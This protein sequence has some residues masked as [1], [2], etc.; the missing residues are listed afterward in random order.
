MKLFAAN[1]MMT[2]ITCVVR[3]CFLGFM[4]ITISGQYLEKS[5]IVMYSCGSLFEVYI[6]CSGVQKLLDVSTSVPDRAFHEA[7]YDR[8][9]STR[10]KYFILLTTTRKIECRVSVFGIVDLTLPSF[11]TILKQAYSACLLLLRIQ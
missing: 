1:A 11:M 8:A 6:L 2:Y 7:W 3:F 5:L 9:T 10:Q 4:L